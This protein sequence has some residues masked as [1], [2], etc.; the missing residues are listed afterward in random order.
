MFRLWRED[1]Y[2]MVG[3]RVVLDHD[4]EGLGLEKLCANAR[5]SRLDVSFCLVWPLRSFIDNGIVL[6]LSKRRDATLGSAVLGFAIHG[7][8]V[9]Q[10][11]VNDAYFRAV[12]E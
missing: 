2:G 4:F 7:D 10:V 3:T 9:C 6:C 1:R 11:K 8:L 12:V 5:P